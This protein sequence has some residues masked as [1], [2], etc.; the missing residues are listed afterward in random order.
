M[1][2]FWK[3]SSF[4]VVIAIMTTLTAHASVINIDVN[5]I[6]GDLTRELRALGE[7]T[8]VNDTLTLNFG[9]GNYTIYG[10]IQFWCNVVV[11]GEGSD[12]TTIILDNGKDKNGFKA[13]KDD[14]FI[15]IIGRLE[16][17]VSVSIRNLSIKLN[18]H[19]GIW[20]ADKEIYAVKLY[21][22]NHV[23]INNVDSYMA[24]ANI[25]NFDMRVC[26]N[27]TVTNCNIT[28]YNNSEIGGCLWVR[29]EA[30][31][32]VISHNKFYK[33]GKDETLAFF[34]RL[35]NANDYIRGSVSRSD[36]I[37]SDNDFYYGGYN[38]EDKN[39]SSINHMI[40]SLFTDNKKSKDEC[41]TSNFKLINNSFHID[42]I[43]T[44]CMYISFDP[45]DTHHGIYI[46]NNTITNSAL[47]TNKMY[48]RQDIEINDL[49]NSNDTI[50]IVGNSITNHDVV[51]N[52][53]GST[54]YSFLLMQGGNVEIKDNKIVNKAT[55]NPSDGKMTGV[56][57][58]WCGVQ[59]GTVTMTDNRWRRKRH[60][61][62]YT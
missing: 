5:T 49:S 3:Y 61:I 55:V 1:K 36:I 50:H 48:Y 54:G 44:R 39:I 10:T 22:S 20:W 40:V 30:H 8:N 32:I 42:D 27:I 56:Q 46:Q 53:S 12:K 57:L 35:V 17:P 18:E 60:R 33:Y 47:N 45:A 43:C 37:V 41:S 38:K 7:K 62:I 15:K 59:G 52:G 26:S 31:N 58:V 24:N 51:N 4:V 6:K 9:K 28:N 25:T 34:S 16:H 19:Q 2:R 29:G 23:E 11:T 21:H 13:F 14:S